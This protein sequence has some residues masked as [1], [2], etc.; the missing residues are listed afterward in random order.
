MKKLKKDL[1]LLLMKQS[2]KLKFRSPLESKLLQ[3]NNY[4]FILLAIGIVQ[5]YFSSH[6]WNKYLPLTEGWWHVY[7][8]WISEGRIPYRDFEL[9]TPPLNPLLINFLSFF[10]VIQRF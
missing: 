5:F 10:I 1:V 9:L 8:R 6:F 7:A 3:Q 2:I 4:F